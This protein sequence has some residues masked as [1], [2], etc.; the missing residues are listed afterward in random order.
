MTE[1]VQVRCNMTLAELVEHMQS[2][3]ILAEMHEITTNEL[4]TF[5][6]AV[7]A[8]ISLATSIHEYREK[9]GDDN[10]PY[11]LEAKNAVVEESE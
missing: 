7:Y 2:E 11:L 5:R 8:F 10:N 3:P 1:D 9:V 4:R 6:S